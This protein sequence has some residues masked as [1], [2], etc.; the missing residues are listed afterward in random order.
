MTYLIAIYIFSVI[1]YSVFKKSNAY[2]SFIEGIM[3]GTQTV[4]NMFAT[5]LSFVLV[6]E[7]IKSCGILDIFKNFNAGIIVQGIIRPLSASS[8][9]AIM[10]DNFNIYGVDSKVSVI[11][12]LIHA[13]LDTVF[14]I[15][16]IYTSTISSKKTKY[17]IVIG[18]ILVIL[19]Y[20]LILIVMKFLYQIYL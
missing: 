11:S 10:I 16:V 5:L 9:F 6:V 12:T 15:I 2:Q 14:Y 7:A 20:I 1:I 13:T 4:V 18:F 3:E 8:S 19:N 17:L